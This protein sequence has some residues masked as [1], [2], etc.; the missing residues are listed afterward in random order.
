MMDWL[1]PR[2]LGR[3]RGPLGAD[4]LPQHHR[5]NPRGAASGAPLGGAYLLAPRSHGLAALIQCGGERSSPRRALAD[6]AEER[7][8]MRKVARQAAMEPGDRLGL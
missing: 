6:A 4:R 8:T 5:G 7:K 1:I 3:G 2:P